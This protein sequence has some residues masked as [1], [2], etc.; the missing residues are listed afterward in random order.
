MT[1]TLL[2][3]AVAIAAA[4]V[5]GYLARIVIECCWLDRETDA[6]LEELRGEL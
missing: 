6:A 1:R 3:L 5:L 2:I 4:G